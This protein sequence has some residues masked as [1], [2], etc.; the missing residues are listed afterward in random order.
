MQKQLHKFIPELHNVR[1]FSNHFKP[2]YE[3]KTV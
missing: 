1:M 2:T 3:Q